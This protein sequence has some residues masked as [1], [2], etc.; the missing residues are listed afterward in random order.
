MEI[1]IQISD[2]DRLAVLDAICKLNALEHCKQ[3]PL[4]SISDVSG[5]KITKVRHIVEDLLEHKLIK[6]YNVSDKQVKPRYYYTLSVAA[7]RLL[8]AA[9]GDMEVT[10]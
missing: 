6:R 9:A 2:E 10:V 8:Q 3:M 1:K 4:K 5:L 7:T